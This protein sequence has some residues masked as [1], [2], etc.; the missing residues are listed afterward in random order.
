[1]Y[2]IKAVSLKYTSTKYIRLGTTK[3]YPR[4]I[5]FCWKELKIE[6]RKLKRNGKWTYSFVFFPPPTNNFHANMAS[7]GSWAAPSGTLWEVLEL[8]ISFI[9]LVSCSFSSYPLN[10]SIFFLH[11]ADLTYAQSSVIIYMHTNSQFPICSLNR[12]LRSRTALSYSS[13]QTHFKSDESKLR[14]TAHYKI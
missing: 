9:L 2:K 14:H 6:P 7:A 3:T 8:P 1:M 5:A 4:Y 11:I 10:I 12:L 13:H